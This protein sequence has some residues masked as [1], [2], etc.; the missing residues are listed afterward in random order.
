QHKG[1][2][3]TVISVADTGIGIRADQ[4]T[5]IFEPFFRS[6]LGTVRG[7][8]LGLTISQE[9]TRLHGG[10]IHVRSVEGVGTTFTV[11]LPFITA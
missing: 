10:D 8:G 2:T 1:M 7:T 6:K 11:L 4:L 9:I 5:H 3:Y